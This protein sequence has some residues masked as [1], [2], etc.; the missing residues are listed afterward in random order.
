MFILSSCSGI[1]YKLKK[2]ADKSIAYFAAE[3]TAISEA[4][5]YFNPLLTDQLQI[6]EEKWCLTYEIGPFLWFSTMWEKQ[7]R[8]WIQTDFKPYTE[9]C[10]WVR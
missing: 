4:P 8:E 2:S 6:T 5:M 9:N 1:P 7:D 3:V 10:N